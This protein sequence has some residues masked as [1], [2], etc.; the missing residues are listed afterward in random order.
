MRTTAL[1][2]IA[3]GLALCAPA[4]NGQLVAGGVFDLDADALLRIDGNGVSAGLG[5][6][7]AAIGDFNGDGRPDFAAAAPGSRVEGRQSAGGVYVVFGGRSDRTVD[8]LD[9]TDPDVAIYG[10][11]GDRIGSS[12]APAGDVNGD[13]L[14]DLILGGYDAVRGG[15]ASGVAYVVFGRRA[16]GPL[17]VTT[18]PAG[19]GFEIDGVAATDRLG[20]AVSGVGDVTGDGLDDVAVAANQADN[21]GY[22]SGSAWVVPGRA[23]AGVVSLALPGSALLRIDGGSVSAQLGWEISRAGDVNGD[24]R[25]DLVVG[26][27]QARNGGVVT[28]AGY[29]VFGGATGTLDVAT[30]GTRG[31][32]LAGTTL[33]DVAGWSVADA[34]DVNRD[35]RA[36]VLISATNAD[37]YGRTNVGSVFLLFGRASGGA[38]DFDALGDDG[39]R[40]NGAPGDVSLG[41]SVARAGDVD[42][43]GVEDMIMGTPNR[44]T[45][46]G[47]DSGRAYVVFGRARPGTI[48]LATL[49]DDGIV[50]DGGVRYG[51]A[52][53]A[54]SPLGDFDGDGL[55]DLLVSANNTRYNGR[56]NSGSAYVVP[57]AKADLR[58]EKEG[59][60]GEVAPGGTIEFAVTV[61][62]DGPGDAADVTLTDTLPPGFLL[63]GLEPTEGSC[64]V[65]LQRIVCSLGRVRAGGGAVIVVRGHAANDANGRLTNTALAS[66]TS[67]QEGPGADEASATVVV[68]GDAPRPP[69]ESEIVVT[70]RADRAVAHV[71]E[72]VTYTVT[73]ANEGD[74]ASG[75]IVLTDA[76]SARTGV[77]DVEL[78]DGRCTRTRPIECRL[79]PLA[80][81]ER[82]TI[83]ARVIPRV[84]GELRNGVAAIG[85]AGQEAGGT[86]DPTGPFDTTLP[87]V[88][89]N[90]LE[91][92][93]ARA[94]L[95]VSKSPRR[96]TVRSGGTLAYALRVAARGGTAT[97]VVLCDRPQAGLTIVAAPGARPIAAARRG[98]AGARAAARHVACWRI[99]R[100][101][102]GTAR[103]FRVRVRV[104]PE[105]RGGRLVNR[106]TAAA[107]GRV[108]ATV[109]ATVT[110]PRAA[111]VPCPPRPPAFTG[112]ARSPR[113]RPSC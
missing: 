25:P 55:V 66:T 77:A 62:N 94:R 79:D 8:A 23:S 58:V 10:G 1:A 7:V 47:V 4:A 38:V 97:S 33:G 9:L 27:T 26:S 52:G 40:I 42:G 30:L 107:R 6:R 36:D 43:D 102:P 44:D 80:P 90:E 67:P 59:T 46:G 69:G 61:V 91:V 16:R 41:W 39:I 28:G 53:Y 49:G 5:F 12:V 3:T 24:G 56:G 74:A 60:P 84:V 75:E 108:R 70:K 78:D 2:A 13:G 29:V 103:A 88:T 68:A 109:R 93:P 86:T 19:G 45:I 85:D 95:V 92:L 54:V 112:A 11:A 104:A 101:A 106:L 57:G 31:I 73:V 65:T 14:D 48:D 15:V 34:G 83:T 71:G 35:G 76:A 37:P 89:E 113:A 17:D 105:F 72:P 87:N 110:V 18:I 82:T 81:G 50:I 96:A 64:T 51:H 100:L 63:D 98:R 22:N 20:V 32:T 99:A 21:N 111:V